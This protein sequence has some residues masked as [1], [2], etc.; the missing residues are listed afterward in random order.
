M[1][2]GRFE[3]FVAVV[4]DDEPVRRA[5]ARLIRSLGFEAEVFSSGEDFVAALATRRPDCVVLDLNMPR[6]DGFEVQA[7]MA[8]AQ[9][10]IPVIVITGHDSPE[11][12]TRALNGGAAAYLRKPVDAGP[13][14]EAIREAV[15]GSPHSNGSAT[16]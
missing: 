10:R 11:A 6:V 12:R 3:C 13:L 15:A 5:L 14:M 7:R 16:Q 4:D 8:Q 2:P 1:S 9:P